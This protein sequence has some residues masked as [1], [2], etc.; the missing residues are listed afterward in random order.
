MSHLTDTSYR[1]GRTRA[2]D[3]RLGCLW[4]WKH[5]AAPGRRNS[6]RTARKTA[7]ALGKAGIREALAE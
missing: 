6:K 4:E 2:H 1:T 7:R 3:S 5:A